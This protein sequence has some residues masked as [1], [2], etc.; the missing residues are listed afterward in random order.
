MSHTYPAV[1]DSVPRA[2]EALST[3]ARSA[4]ATDDQLDSIRLAVSE[5]TTNVVVHAYDDD[6]GRIQ[7]DAGL[8]AGELW[9]QIA[10]DGLGMRPQIQSPGLGFGLS[11]ISQVCDKFEIAKRSSG[12]LEVRMRF[13][14][15]G[16]RMNW[17]DG[18][19][20]STFRFAETA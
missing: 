14:L 17:A 4:G 15:D 12:G 13:A 2:R 16:G 6:S 18:T 9:V 20:R 10:D 5:A 8:A 3:F 11:L 19:G 1:A 7:L